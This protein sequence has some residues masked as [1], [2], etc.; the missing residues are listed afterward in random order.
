MEDFRSADTNVEN[1]T[2]KFDAAP[3]MDIDLASSMFH[4]EYEEYELRI[5]QLKNW[6]CF[7]E[8]KEIPIGVRLLLRDITSMNIFVHLHSASSFRIQVYVGVHRLASA[9]PQKKVSGA[10]DRLQSILRSSCISLLGPPIPPIL[11]RRSSWR[12]PF[13][14]ACGRQQLT[15]IHCHLHRLRSLPLNTRPTHTFSS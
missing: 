12:A 10:A 11:L 13:A 9:G 7:Q 2:H 5:F 15:L 14:N 4:Q 3:K 8:Y 6:F 1:T